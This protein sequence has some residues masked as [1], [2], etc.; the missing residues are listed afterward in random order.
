MIPDTW[1]WTAL[2]TGW[3]PNVAATLQ[4]PPQLSANLG[5][6]IKQRSRRWL[7]PTPSAAWAGNGRIMQALQTLEK[8][9][10]DSRVYTFDFSLQPEIQAGDALTSANVTASPSDNNLI[11]LAPSIVSPEVQVVIQNGNPGVNYLVTC[12]AVT[13]GAQTGTPA[14]IT[15]LGK[16]YVVDPSTL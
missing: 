2:P 11:L 12:V 1:Q 6:T 7:L 10:E 9:H 16:L 15:A 4:F 8:F 3:Q 5:W 13:D 14:T